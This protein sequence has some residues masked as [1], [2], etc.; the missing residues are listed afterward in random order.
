MDRQKS[1]ADDYLTKTNQIYE[2]NK[3]LRK[4]NQD[5]DKTDSLIGKN[6]LKTFSEIIE[7]MQ[8]REKLSKTD[9]EIA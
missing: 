2:T 6:K 8:E 7:A 9:L 4:I 3:M 1:L 5:I